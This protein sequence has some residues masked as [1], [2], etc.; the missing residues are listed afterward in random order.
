MR[1]T[2]SRMP[3]DLIWLLLEV[4]TAMQEHASA[5]LA[6]WQNFYVIVGS[7]A[8][9]LTGLQFVVITLIAEARVTSSM[10]EIRAFGSPTTVHF[11]M[12]LLISAFAACPWNSLEHVG[13]VLAAGGVGGVIYAFSAIRHAR[14]QTGYLP[15]WGDWMWFGWLPVVIYGALAGV[16][17]LL[18]TRAAAGLFSLAGI[19][20]ALLFLGIHNSWDTV[21]YIAIGHTA[22]EHGGKR[23]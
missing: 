8:G 3:G 14:N 18:P 23:D 9:A 1:T 22:Q 6:S 10:R 13:Y 21:T 17:F 20:L 15:D 2:D 16:G 5:A 4:P 11:C 12:V 19:A 7:S